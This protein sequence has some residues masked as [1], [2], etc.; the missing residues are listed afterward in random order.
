MFVADWDEIT[1]TKTSG[2]VTPATRSPRRRGS[3]R[4]QRLVG[5]GDAVAQRGCPGI[6][7][8]GRTAG[9]YDFPPVASTTRA[10]SIDR[11]GVTR[12]KP[13]PARAKSTRGSPQ[14][15]VPPLR[16]RRRRHTPRA[17]RMP[18]RW[19]KTNFPPRSTL[20]G[21]PSAANRSTTAS[22]PTRGQRR[23]ATAGGP[24]GLD[25]AAGIAGMGQVAPS[26]ARQQDLD[27]RL[28]VLLQ[29]ERPQSARSGLRRGHQPGWSRPHDCHI[30]RHPRPLLPGTLPRKHNLR[31]LTAGRNGSADRR[32]YM[33]ERHVAA[34]G[35]P[36]VGDRLSADRIF[37]PCQRA[38]V[39]ERGRA[40]QG[41]LGPNHVFQL[42]ENRHVNQMA[43]LCRRS[44]GLRPG[45]A[46]TVACSPAVVRDQRCR[47]ARL[48][49]RRAD[50]GDRDDAA[51]GQHAAGQADGLLMLDAK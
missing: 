1:R 10:A 17:R 21:T 45:A 13:S 12:R 27:A 24:E 41:M 49:D 48:E 30:P 16:R 34:T 15:S 22:G 42:L 29:Q 18:D 47:C 26:A 8:A 19:R 7:V 25:N 23:A 14:A 51:L 11:C 36:V 39:T 31:S 33:F 32:S 28:A 35:D 40:G 20:V 46:S 3:L 2:R 50:F 9:G 44:R 37:D 5:G 43:A 4:A 38:V 6:A